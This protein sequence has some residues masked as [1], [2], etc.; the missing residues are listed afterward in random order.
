MPQLTLIT[1]NQ[2]SL[3]N[4]L[5]PL[6]KLL[7]FSFLSFIQL[8]LLIWIFCTKISFQPFLITQL[9]ENTSLQISNSL[10]IPMVFSVLITEFMYYLVVISIYIF[11]S[12]IM[13]T[14][15]LSTLIRTKHQNLFTTDISGPASIL[16]CNNSAGPVMQSKPQYHKSYRSLK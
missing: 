12:I 9:L 10:L 6:H 5:G 13:I 8:Q 16:I 4:K 1:S 2:S 11:S 3:K 7:S 15:Q 14:F